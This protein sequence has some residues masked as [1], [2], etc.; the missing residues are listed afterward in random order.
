M[1]NFLYRKGYNEEP[2]NLK[3]VKLFLKTIREHNLISE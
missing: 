3:D 1:T 2:E